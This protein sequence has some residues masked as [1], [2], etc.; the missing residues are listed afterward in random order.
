MQMNKHHDIPNAKLF[1]RR[2]ERKGLLLISL[3]ILSVPILSS[4]AHTPET[5]ISPGTYEAI[6]DA[7]RLSRILAS[8]REIRL[9]PDRSAAERTE[10]SVTTLESAPPTALPAGLPVF[11]TVSSE[12]GLRLDPFS[13]FPEFHK[14]IDIAAARGTPVSATAGGDVIWAGLQGNY[15]KT[16]IMGRDPV[17]KASEPLL[18]ETRLEIPR[19]VLKVREPHEI[20]HV[21]Q[22][23]A[24]ERLLLPAVHPW[25]HQDR[26]P[27]RPIPENIGQSKAENH[28][29]DLVRL[30][31]ENGERCVQVLRKPLAFQS[32]P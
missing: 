12:F 10:A 17:R 18:V 27:E 4:V 15:G 29:V 28:D 13:G 30:P 22:K 9:T 25:E 21:L 31:P 20:E 5:A 32:C 23:P 24:R 11:G 14:G 19:I 16:V 7:D 6:D 2:M 1:A 3:L 8:L 26:D